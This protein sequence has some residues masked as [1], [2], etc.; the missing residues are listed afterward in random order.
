MKGA[1]I[2]IYRDESKI[3]AAIAQTTP[4]TSNPYNLAGMFLHCSYQF[5]NNIWI[6]RNVEDV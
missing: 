5:L 2:P 3:H 4:A 6:E 1:I